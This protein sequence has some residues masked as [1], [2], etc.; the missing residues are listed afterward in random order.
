MDPDEAAV[1]DANERFYVAFSSRDFAAM[2]RLWAE[3]QPVTCVHP[4]W[5]LIEGREAVLRSWAGILS[6]P[7]QARVLSGGA[8]VVVSGDLAFVVCREWVS[9]LPL[10]VTNVFVRED[11]EWRMCHH[12]SGPVAAEA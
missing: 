11:G 12:H 5:N 4:G 2:G 1:L 3:R 8:K 10:L 6:N 9:G 7:A